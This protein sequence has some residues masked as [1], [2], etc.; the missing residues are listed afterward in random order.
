[1]WIDV[2]SPQQC[3]P[4]LRTFVVFVLPQKCYSTTSSSSDFS[5]NI[6]STN[7][8]LGLVYSLARQHL[9]FLRKNSITNVPVVFMS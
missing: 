5:M 6:E 3:L 8:A 2:L 9:L 1:M 7:V 4:P